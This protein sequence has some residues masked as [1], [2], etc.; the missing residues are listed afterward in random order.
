[1]ADQESN[2][3]SKRLPR[4][5]ASLMLRCSELEATFSR[6]NHTPS[7]PCHHF[8]DAPENGRGG[9]SK[10]T[11]FLSPVLTEETMSPRKETPRAQSPDHMS[12]EPPALME[13]AEE[14]TE[15]DCCEQ[16]SLKSLD[17]STEEENSLLGQGDMLETSP[18][19]DKKTG[20]RFTDWHKNRMA[21]VCSEQFDRLLRECPEYQGAKS[22]LAAFVLEREVIDTGGQCCELYEVVA[23]G[24]GQN[25]CSG[26]LCFTGSVVHDCHAIVIAR[27]ALKRYLYKQLLLY[28]SSDPKCTQLSIFECSSD[29]QLLHLKPK[30]Y[31]HLYTNQTP[32]G[33]AQCIIM[34]SQSSSYPSLKLQCYTKG[35]LIPATFLPPSIW[36]ARICCMSDSAKLTRWTVIGVQGALLSHFI[37]PVYITSLTLGDSRNYSGKVA[38]TINKR[39]GTG[40]EKDLPPAYRPTSIFFLN[41]E[42]AGP[43]VSSTQYKDL[44]INWCFG[45]SSIEILDSTTGLAINSSP[46][47]S[48]PGFSSRL[49]KRA[50]YFSFRKVAVQAEQEAL[51]TFSTY[52]KAKM[53]ACDYQKAK[54]VVSQQFLTNSA[55]PWNSKQ[56]VD[57]FC[58]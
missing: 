3:E 13:E 35:S 20:V 43:S 50:L 46:F 29:S 51:L 34:R 6:A 31:L 15:E 21:T 30:L 57:S 1:M 54:S 36:A 2:G 4:M 11:A 14:D 25:C 44:S 38:D 8:K 17:C 26:W 32:K 19:R 18:K 39:L 5:A 58:R 53:A 42:S 52:R 7:P 27:R 24:T 41:G 55:G 22:C 49:C 23:M 28:Y 9:R 16:Y 56:L 10:S 37:Q 12:L 47:V 48:G 45:D 40:F 33:A